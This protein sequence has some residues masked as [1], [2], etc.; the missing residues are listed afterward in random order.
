MS[1]SASHPQISARTIPL[2]DTSGYRRTDYCDGSSIRIVESRRR[3]RKVE[4]TSP[5]PSL[6]TSSARTSS[7]SFPSQRVKT[8]QPS[9]CSSSLVGRKSSGPKG[10][11]IPYSSQP[12]RAKTVV[13]HSSFLAKPARSCTTSQKHGADPLTP[14]PTPRMGRLPTPE[15]DDLDQ[16]PFCDCCIGM[17]SVK[18]CASCGQSLDGSRC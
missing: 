16:R 1:S 9:S 3:P 2:V 12:S 11:V 15:L 4:S 18:Y 13:V 6:H 14:P 5:V 7:S 10:H 17:G 8:S